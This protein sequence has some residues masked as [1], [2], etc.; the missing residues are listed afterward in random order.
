MTEPVAAPAGPSPAS[1]VLRFDDVH[2]AAGQAR[3]H[4]RRL[5][6]ELLSA[7]R[8]TLLRAQDH[9]RRLRRNRLARAVFV[10][11]LVDLVRFTW[12]VPPLWKILD[13]VNPDH[14]R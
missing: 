5:E 2:D 12:Q 6:R 4:W 14:S 10:R 3:P 11:N 8:A 9:V 13:L 1:P 7:D